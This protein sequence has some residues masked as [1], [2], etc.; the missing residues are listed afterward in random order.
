MFAIAYKWQEYLKNQLAFNATKPFVIIKVEVIRVLSI[1]YMVYCFH[2]PFAGI[3]CFTL[4]KIWV[5]R[6]WFQ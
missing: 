4:G 6:K 1:F 3:A 2:L 5:Y